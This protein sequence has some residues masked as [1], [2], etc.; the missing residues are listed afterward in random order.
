MEH[1]ALNDLLKPIVELKQSLTKK[2]LVRARVEGLLKDADA[3]VASG[4]YAAKADYCLAK[5]AYCQFHHHRF[6]L[7]ICCGLVTWC[8]FFVQIIVSSAKSRISAG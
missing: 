7:Q 8:V 1:E 3:A 2:A 6:Y 5:L 4:K